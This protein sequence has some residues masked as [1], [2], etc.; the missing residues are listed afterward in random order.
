MTKNNILLIVI[1]IS[2]FQSRILAQK[3]VIPLYSGQIPNSLI[4]PDS[5]KENLDTNGLFTKISVPTLTVFPPPKGTENG[6]AVIILP[7]GG[8]GCL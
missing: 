1:L 8:T 5:Y 6:T 3:T 2:F 4:T 7:S